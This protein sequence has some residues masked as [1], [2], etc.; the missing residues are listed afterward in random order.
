MNTDVQ[1]LDTVEAG[2]KVQLGERCTRGLGA[3]GDHTTGRK[4]AEESRE[5][6]REA[7]S[8]ADL[9]F[10]TAGMGGGTGTVPH[11]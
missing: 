11:R 4:A 3:G 6:I 1:A 8:G 10:I 9:L 7:I 5:V 2:I